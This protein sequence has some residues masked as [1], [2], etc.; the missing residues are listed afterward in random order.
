M[1]QTY[2][3]LNLYKE[4]LNREK[5]EEEERAASQPEPQQE[6]EPEPEPEQE[7]YGDVSYQ[8]EPVHRQ[9]PVC[10]GVTYTRLSTLQKKITAI[11]VYVFFLQCRH[12]PYESSTKTYYCLNK[13]FSVTFTEVFEV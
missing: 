8:P 12:K 9:V 6:P 5:L 11:T 1:I 4:R 10:S 7:D 2:T 3:F 13:H